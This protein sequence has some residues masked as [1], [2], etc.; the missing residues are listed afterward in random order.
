MKKFLFLVILLL[1]VISV[2]ASSRIKKSASHAEFV[3][4]EKIKPNQKLSSAPD[5]RGSKVIYVSNQSE[6]DNVMTLINQFVT[7]GATKIEVVFKPGRYLFRENHFDFNQKDYSELAIKFVGNGAE[8]I[9]SGRQYKDGDVFKDNYEN[10]FAYIDDSLREVSFWGKMHTTDRKLDVVDKNTKL[11]R[12]H[13]NGIKDYSEIECKQVYIFISQ[14]FRARYFKVSYIKADYIYFIADD[15]APLMGDYNINFDYLVSKQREYTRFK[16]C[17]IPNECSNYIK[18]G[19]IHFQHGVK[20]V[21][22]CNIK[23]LFHFSESKLKYVE[24]EGFDFCGNRATSP[25]YPQSLIYLYSCSFLSGIYV[26]D[27]S[28]NSLKSQALNASYTDNIQLTHNKLSNLYDQGF[29]FTN[30]CSN[31]YVTHNE[32]AYCGLNLSPVGC[33]HCAG[34]NYYIGYNTFKN[35]GYSAIRLGNYH[36]NTSVQGSKGVAEYNQIYFTGDYIAKKKDYTMMDGGAIYLFTQNDQ[37][38]VRYNSIRNYTGMY[39][40]TGIYLDDGAYNVIVYG[41]VVLNI[42]NDRNIYSRREAIERNPNVTKTVTTSNSGN[43]I[44]YNIVDGPCMFVANEI[45][46]NCYQGYNVVFNT[47][48]ISEWE[49]VIRNFD[50]VEEDVLIAVDSIPTEGKISLNKTVLK[51]VKRLPTYKKIQKLL[52]L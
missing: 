3:R 41:N 48:K 23:T 27:C 33:V 29:E 6:F 24:V 47:G 10:S 45:C 4:Y 50:S 44:M 46:S 2:N 14:S 11:C 49:H 22:Q 52:N 7:R 9:G 12:I 31:I 35:F 16:L 18:D 15:L 51:Q 42:E 20:F 21:Y 5:F 34:R 40:N 36:G 43:V 28:F 38:I 17:N 13:F 39:G 1:G 26:H 30:S 37:A 19:K 25:N 8:L 32:F